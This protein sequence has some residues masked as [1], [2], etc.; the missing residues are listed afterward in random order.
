[1]TTGLLAFGAGILVNEAF[2]D[3]D[4]D[5]WGGGYGYPPPYYPVYGNG[6]GPSYKYNNNSNNNIYINNGKNDYWNRFDHNGS[7]NRQPRSPISDAQRRPADWKG[8]GSYDGAGARPSLQDKA[9][10]VADRA[11]RQ[12]IEQPTGSYAGATKP[13]RTIAGDQN[14][15]RSDRGRQENLANQRQ[16]GGENRSANVRPTQQPMR[17]GENAQRQRESGGGALQGLNNKGGFERTA[18]ARGKASRGGGGDRAQR[19]GGGRR[20]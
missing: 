11:A 19:S 14:M 18:S 9:P 8:K 5:Y 17:Q 10:G 7:G 20:R 4:D 6:Y 15:S 16:Q 3:D 12:R 1:V 2:D 13:T